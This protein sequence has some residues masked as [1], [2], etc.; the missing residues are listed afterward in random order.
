MYGHTYSKSID[1]PGKIASPARGQLTRKMNIPCPR[2]RLRLWS[3]EKGSTVPIRASLLISIL[4][5]DL[6][7]VSI[8]A[9]SGGGEYFYPLTN[10]HQVRTTI[11]GIFVLPLVLFVC[12]PRTLLNACTGLRRR[13]GAVAVETRLAIALR[14]MAGASYID[15]AVL[16]GVAKET[17]FHILWQVVDAINRTPA[18][19]PFFLPRT[20]DDCTRQAKQWE[21]VL[22]LVE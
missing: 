8:K 19:G 12:A 7:E 4:K 14:M 18:V 20:M 16:F 17:V 11:F 5:L 6:V 10:L 22:T 9:G 1:Q 15:V 2:L 13:S 21:H 3:H